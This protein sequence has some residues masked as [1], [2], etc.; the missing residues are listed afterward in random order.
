[1]QSNNNSITAKAVQQTTNNTTRWIGHRQGDSNDIIGG[2]TFLS[3]SDGD[4]ESIEVFSSVITATGQCEMTFYKFD[5][6]H[7][8]WGQ[9]LGSATLKLNTDDAGKWISFKIPGLHINK[10]ESYGF[11]LQCPDT[12]IGVGEAAGSH[13]H[14]PFNNGQEWR[15]SPTDQKGHS[16]SYFSLAFKVGLRA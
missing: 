15:F 9:A 3:P 16:F 5:A 11:R 4:L 1:M 13:Q 8:S 7:K 14:P 12:L 6:D 2:Q 10:G